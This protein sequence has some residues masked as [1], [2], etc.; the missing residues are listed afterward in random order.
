MKTYSENEGMLAQLVALGVL[1][2]T[3]LQELEHGLTVEVVL[4]ETEV[5]YRCMKCARDGIMDVERP[6]ELPGEPRLQRCSKC[7]VARYC[8]KTCQRED[9]DLHKQ[10]CKLWDTRPWE[11]ARLMENRR[12]AEITNFLDSAGFQSI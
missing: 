2:K 3:P 10:D 5:S 6:F 4:E 1:R 12:R 9:W 8:N 11:A 7:K